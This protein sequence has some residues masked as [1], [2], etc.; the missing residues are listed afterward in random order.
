MGYRTTYW[1]IA[2]GQ[3]LWLQDGSVSDTI[4]VHPTDILEGSP[5]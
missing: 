4:K 1:S 2:S 5:P 3:Y